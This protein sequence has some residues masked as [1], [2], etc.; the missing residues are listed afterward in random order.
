M[1][2]DTSLPSFFRFNH[3][4]ERRS[5]FFLSELVSVARTR[6]LC[7]GK[8]ETQV[9]SI[10]ILPNLNHSPFPFF[11]LSVSRT[12]KSLACEMFQDITLKHGIQL[13]GFQVH[14]SGNR[15]VVVAGLD[16]L[17][18]G[19]ATQ[20]LQVSVRDLKDHF[21]RGSDSRLHS[22]LI[23]LAS[24]DSDQPTPI[25]RCF[26]IY[27]ISTSLWDTTNMQVFRSIDLTS[28][29]QASSLSHSE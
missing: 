15:V 10:D 6:Q 2:S 13:G 14:S 18:K 28:F 24:S 29:L 23:S 3:D 5:S 1:G 4:L 12:F 8:S 9:S 7:F 20:C 17:L 11:L 19:A 25:S 22:A 26:P 27:R 16:N 21:P